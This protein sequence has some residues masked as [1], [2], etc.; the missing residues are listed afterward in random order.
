MPSEVHDSARRWAK[1]FDDPSMGSRGQAT[2][3]AAREGADILPTLVEILIGRAELGH[4]FNATARR[5]AVIAM[6]NLGETA[7]PAKDT[8]VAVLGDEDAVLRLEAAAALGAM[9]AKASAAVPMLAERLL[10]ADVPG[11]DEAF[12][13]AKALANIGGENAVQG[14]LRAL[15]GDA[16]LHGQIAAISAI[17]QLG[18][19]AIVAVPR[20]IE[21]WRTSSNNRLRERCA[22]M[23]M[24]IDPTAAD[25][26]G[27]R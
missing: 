20:L 6:R 2:H 10:R 22:A 12:E 14:L 13:L 11:L 9:G 15:S 21:L 3:D 26:A 16:S 4:S 8:L 27:I 1:R 18:S 19:G 24:R 23:L 7:A 17:P 25:R 5:G